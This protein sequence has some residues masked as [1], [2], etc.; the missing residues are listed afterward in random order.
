MRHFIHSRR[1]IV[2]AAAV[3]VLLLVSAGL[4]LRFAQQNQQPKNND[5]PQSLAAGVA[6]EDMAKIPIYPNA[7]PVELPSNERVSGALD[8]TVEAYR[9]DVLVFYQ[10]ALPNKGWSLYYTWTPSELEYIWQDPNLSLPYLLH[11][12][13]DLDQGNVLVPPADLYIRIWREP[14]PNNIQLLNDAQNVQ[15]KDEV[16]V[17]QTDVGLSRSDNVRTI[18]YLTGH[19]PEDILTFYSNIL[20]LYGWTIDNPDEPSEPNFHGGLHEGT[21]YHYYSSDG[22]PSSGAVVNIVITP[23]TTQQA[24][25]QLKIAG[26]R[27]RK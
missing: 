1:N 2:I 3:L 10:N 13:V 12:V 8:Y 16:M 27:L 26:S 25:V 9:Q 11:L 5:T 20:P 23:G 4:T 7:I 6:S 22:G 19:K 18:S 15:T 24:E 17:S 21:T 14:D